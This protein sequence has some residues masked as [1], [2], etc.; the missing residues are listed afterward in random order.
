MIERAPAAFSSEKKE[1]MQKKYEEYL[2]D[3][4]IARARVEET[5]ILFGKEIW[6]YHKAWQEVYE[7]YG[8]QKEAEYFEK[9]LPKELH[10]KYFAC[11][12]KGGGHCLR[13]YRMCGLME[14]CFDP[15]E[16]VFLDETVIKT[17]GKTRKDIDRL[18]TG[19]KKNEFQ[20]LLEKWRAAQKEMAAGIEELKKMAGANPKWRAEILDKVKT[21]EQGWSIIEQ[22]I[23]LKDIEQ[24]IDFYKGAIESP[25]AY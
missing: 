4:K 5:V 21:I 19:S 13:E 8:R 24:L 1:E 16:K 14:T 22:D 3:K 9:E 20:K 11:K 7:K 12:V 25:E 15:D 18:T 6:P 10:D 2:K 23:N 17:L